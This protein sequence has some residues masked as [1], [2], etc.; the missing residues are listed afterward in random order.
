MPSFHHINLYILPRNKTMSWEWM[1]DSS[2]LASQRIPPSTLRT[3]LSL[4]STRVPSTLS[5][6]PHTRLNSH[7]Y[8]L[9]WVDSLSASSPCDTPSV[10]C[11][12]PLIQNVSKSRTVSIA[13][14]VVHPDMPLQV[15]RSWI[16]VLLIWAERTNIAWI[17]VGQAVSIVFIR[18]YCV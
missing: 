10:N 14:R 11:L 8:S 5:Q 7:P 16:P 12:R 4:V 3:R 18:Q 6:N 15:I 1:V 13:I 17:C 2:S 9:L